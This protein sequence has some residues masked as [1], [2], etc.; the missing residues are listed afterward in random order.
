MI[1]GGNSK[2]VVLCGFVEGKQGSIYTGE[3]RVLH[4]KD[5]GVIGAEAAPKIGKRGWV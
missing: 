4:L 5:A 2:S 3:V 1:E